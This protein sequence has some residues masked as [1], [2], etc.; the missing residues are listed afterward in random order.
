MTPEQKTYEEKLDFYT[1]KIGF[2]KQRMDILTDIIASGEETPLQDNTYELEILS[3]RASLESLEHY[4][5]HYKTRLE[6]MKKNE[7]ALTEECK[8]NFGEYL[9]R[10]NNIPLQDIEGF[11]DAMKT[12]NDKVRGAHIF[13]SQEEENDMFVLMKEFLNIYTK[14]K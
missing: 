8:A 5:N 6:A 3:L 10:I 4:W 12:Y 1:Q 2:T 9:A 7:E 11:S 14:T 13:E